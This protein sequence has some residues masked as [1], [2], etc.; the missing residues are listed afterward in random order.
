MKEDKDAVLLMREIHE[1]VSESVARGEV[2]A[3]H[4]IP[5]LAYATG[6]AVS[7]LEYRDR[8]ED[9]YKE[10]ALDNFYDGV[11]SVKPTAIFN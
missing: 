1:L 8:S 7:G 5:A 3:D 9:D 11:D 6:V 4:I 10:W 2:N